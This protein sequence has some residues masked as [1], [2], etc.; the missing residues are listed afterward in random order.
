MTWATIA[1]YGLVIAVIVGIVYWISDQRYQ[2]GYAQGF[3]DG[4][5]EAVKETNEFRDEQFEK[6]IA[7]RGE[8]EEQRVRVL[9]QSYRD[10][11]QEY[12]KQIDENRQT[13]N[14][15]MLNIITERDRT[16]IELRDARAARAIRD[17]IDRSRLPQTAATV[18][19]GT[20]SAGVLSERGEGRLV[21]RATDAEQLNI[22]FGQCNRAYEQIRTGRVV[23]P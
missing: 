12:A 9:M 19:P 6:L 13:A 14:R 2:A 15:D 17:A 8:Q 10:K 22:W 20:V 1:K 11:E 5:K 4:K 7:Q 3:A 16:L 23:Q 18:A 21:G